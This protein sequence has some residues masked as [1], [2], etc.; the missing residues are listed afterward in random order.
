MTTNIPNF[1]PHKCRT[2]IRSV[3]C[4]I[5]IIITLNLLTNFLKPIPTIYIYY[6]ELLSTPTVSYTHCQ[7]EQ[8]HINKHTHTSVPECPF[9][10]VYL[11]NSPAARKVSRIRD[12]ECRYKLLPLS[13]GSADEKKRMLIHHNLSSDDLDALQIFLPWSWSNR[14]PDPVLSSPL[15][16]YNNSNYFPYNKYIFKRA[17]LTEEERENSECLCYHFKPKLSPHIWYDWPCGCRKQY[18]LVNSHNITSDELDLLSSDH[19]T[20]QSDLAYIIAPLDSD[21]A[22]RIA[23][24]LFLYYVVIIF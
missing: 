11:L 20:L 15:E 17:Q 9:N 22:D 13:H 12:K 8:K 24:N 18:H 1:H 5:I 4:L 16:T 6:F 3:S 23:L 21:P 19:S 2:Q 14:Y 10:N 7:F